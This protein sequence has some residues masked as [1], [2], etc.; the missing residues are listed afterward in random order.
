MHPI[1]AHHAGEQAL[2]PLLLLASG[3]APL[4][5]AMGRERLAAA[6]AKLTRPRRRP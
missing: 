6:R 2:A 5:V 4:L 3:G 1:V